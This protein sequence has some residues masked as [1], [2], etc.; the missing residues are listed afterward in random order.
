M[1]TMHKQKRKKKDYTAALFENDYETRP[2]P[3][4]YIQ[5]TVSR[6]AD[7]ENLV[8]HSKAA[9]YSA[10]LAQK[11]AWQRNAENFNVTCSVSEVEPNSCLRTFE[12]LKKKYV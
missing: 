5:K 8:V 11:T 2:P 10:I 9:D 4:T 3:L 1:C 6:E 7:R 12:Y